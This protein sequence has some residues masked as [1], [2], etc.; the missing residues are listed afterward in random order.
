MEKQGRLHLYPTVRGKIVLFLLIGLLVF[1]LY[2]MAASSYAQENKTINEDKETPQDPVDL[3][4]TQLITQVAPITGS[5]LAIGFDYLRRRGIQISVDAEK[6]FTDSISSLAARQSKLIYEELR[7]NKAYWVQKDRDEYKIT[8]EKNFPKSLGVQAKDNVFQHLTKML[9]SKEFTGHARKMLGEN[10]S[11]LIEVAV[12]KNNKELTERGR[13]LIHDLA[14][15]AVDSLLLLKDRDTAKNQ[16]NEIIK[17][18]MEAIQKNFDF[19]EI[20]FDK[21]FAEMFVRAE[22]NKKLGDAT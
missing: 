12:T 4:I 18:A 2:N 8:K 15:L 10:L 13:N 20:Q 17:E 5:I 14:P 21:N 7:D 16:V 22:L 6:Y 9:T 3:I 19:E 1:G 11:E